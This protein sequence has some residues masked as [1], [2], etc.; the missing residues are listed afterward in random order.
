MKITIMDYLRS[1]VFSYIPYK[2]L[3][4]LKP[5][6]FNLSQI[7]FFYEL[8]RFCSVF[9]LSVPLHEMQNVMMQ[10]H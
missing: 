9:W 10:L 8:C 5:S 1:L 6:L 2:S 7:F 3:K 4:L